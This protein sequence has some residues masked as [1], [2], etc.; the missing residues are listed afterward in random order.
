MG[1]LL[2]LCSR[3]G[4]KYL[5]VFSHCSPTVVSSW[6]YPSFLN[7]TK[8]KK[9]RRKKEWALCPPPCLLFQALKYAQITIR[10]SC[11]CHVAKIGSA[12]EIHHFIC[13]YKSV[14]F[15][16]P[17][18]LILELFGKKKWGMGIQCLP[19]CPSMDSLDSESMSFDTLA[20]S[21]LILND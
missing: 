15:Y 21:F 19:R 8:N 2:N 11:S 12:F 17:E 18:L 1:V 7:A 9:V 20:Y 16:P 14:F 6:I 4:L 3:S 5:K 10:L 13:F